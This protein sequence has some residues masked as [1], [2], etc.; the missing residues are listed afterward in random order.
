MKKYFSAL[1][2][3]IFYFLFS[4]FSS[5]QW[6]TIPDA[7]FRTWLNN[8]GYGSCMSGNQMD[9][10]CAAVV[11]ATNIDC[12]YQNIAN[13]QGI[14]YFDN[15]HR[16]KCNNN[17]LTNIPALPHNLLMLNCNNNQLPN[18]PTLPNTLD[19]LL[20]EYNSITTLPSLPNSIQ[21]LDCSH[22]TMVN[23]PTLPTSLIRM[24][25]DY[26][27]LNA[28]PSL[29]S[30]LQHLWCSNNPFTSLPPLNNSL[31]EIWCNNCP[32]LLSFPALPN[33]MYAV[34]CG[35]CPH[36]N[37]L[38]A[39]N[40]G[41]N[42]LQFVS[43]SLLSV[44]SF[45]SSL[46]SIIL[47]NNHLTSIPALPGNVSN[48]HLDN[49]P[50]TILPAL[51]ASIHVLYIDNIL[52]NSITSL[53]PALTI[54]SCMFDNLTNLP[55][56]PQTLHILNVSYNNLQFIPD[57]PDSIQ[58]LDVS[59]NPLLKCLPH[60]TYIAHYLRFNNTLISCLPNII[61]VGTSSTPNV[62]TIPLCGIFN[63][64]S[65]PTYWNLSGKV[66][67]DA[68]QDSIYS[69]GDIALDNMKIKLFHNGNLVQQ[70]YSSP[71][72]DYSF[73]TDTFSFYQTI[74]DTNNTPFS[75]VC[76]GNGVDTAS[77]SAND[78]LK[79]NR[80]FAMKCAPG[81]DVGVTS[82]ARDSGMF[83]PNNYTLVKITAGDMSNFYGVHCASGISGQVQLTFTGSATYAGY[84][85]G[86]LAPTNISGN[87]VT[88]NIADFGLVNFNTDFHTRL[89]I[90]TSA[91]V[92]S[93]ICFNVVVMPTAGDND[94]A[95]NQW[96]FC[97]QCVNSFD[98]NE[99]E[100]SPRDTAVIN[101]W[102]TYT[103]HFQNTGTA[104]AQHIY[105]DDTL[106]TNLDASTFQLLSYSVAPFVQIKGN[107]VRFNFP[108]INLPDSSSNEPASHGYVQYRIKPKNNLLAGT[109]I[110]NTAFIYFDFNPPVI[111]DTTVNTIAF[112]NG[113]NDYPFSILHF[114]LFPNP[115]TDELNILFSQQ[116]NY[117]VKIVDEL[118]REVFSRATSIQHPTFN[119]QHLFSGIYF[120][121]VKSKDGIATEKFVKE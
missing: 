119:I 87:V 100:V 108:N 24:Y 120:V 95:N 40:Q 51:P 1:L 69:G 13:L 78:S 106:D 83:F 66:F 113:T 92:G 47:D 102:L 21:D 42:V 65:C 112:A 75:M 114:Q 33:S 68:N 82:V 84:K 23:L 10:T 12:S 11:N 94:V 49:N 2:F 105:V 52:V 107:A 99:K 26:C 89:H 80:N 48:L 86:S 71:Y 9:T 39:L 73:D 31:W 34:I 27:N 22:N 55:Q 88:W 98:P 41:L 57:V 118:G 3:S 77:V 43:D 32:N 61:T 18:L 76:P 45:P 116:G 90:D 46:T 117:E 54:L 14:Q 53:P 59:H 58:T 101:D 103:I 81:F 74:I 36:I 37:S 8:Q 79:W 67:D 93:S 17:V 62:D 44:A 96:N 30:S 6:V 111:T 16:L 109:Q 15:L 35:G 121:S 91:L 25:C 63:G 64:G 29:P 56:L 115:A 4:P 110:K 104:P 97:G 19:S 70:V 5:A 72:G 28:L 38:P 50:I 20:C 7:N 60:V 85:A